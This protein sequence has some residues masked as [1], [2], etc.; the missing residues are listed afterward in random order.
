MKE[1]TKMRNFSLILSAI[2][3]LASAGQT[4]A[5]AAPT[6]FSAGC[7]TA[8]VKD[9]G[10]AAD[11]TTLDT[12]AINKTIEACSASGGGTVYF[13]AGTYLSGSIR[14]KSNIA[15]Y[16]DAGATIL[17]ASNDINAYDQ[18]ED[19]T[20]DMYQDFGHSHWHNSLIWGENL[21]NITIMGPGTINGGGMTRGD[22]VPGG[23]DKTIA[24]KL[25]R[26][27]LIKDIT[28][29]HAGHFAI[30]LTGCDNMVID[31]VKVDTNRDGINLDCCRNVRVSN[32]TINSPFDDAL[33]LKS[34]YALGYKRATEN[35]TITNCMVS[36]YVEGTMLDGTYD[37]TFTRHEGTGGIK[38]GT[39]SN[40]GFKNIV[41]D[42]CVFDNCAGFSLEIVDGGIME[43]INISNITARDITSVPIFIRLGNR[44]R[45]PDNPPVGKIRNINI[46]NVLVTGSYKM[47]GS[48]ITGI[49]GHP[50]ENIRL[51]NIKIIYDGGGTKQDAKIEP[52][53]NEKSYPRSDMFGT[54]PSY[55]FYCRHVKGLEFHNVELGFEEQ[56]LRPALICDDVIDLELDNFKAERAAGGEPSIVLKNVKDIRVH[57]PN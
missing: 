32:C 19:N 44:A 37:N 34:S 16:L 41:I 5:A 57:G 33:C 51:N 49:P 24:L 36:G 26:N 48:S 18:P 46:S 11:G 40:G 13:P 20:F 43:N 56:D 54:L 2:L 29:R 21:E 25:C 45:G 27:I 50:V 14:L 17:G 47:C 30:L 15:L 53:E 7:L 28:I 23:G 38:F 6:V 22:P 9:Y 52:S 1:N 3:V 4:A 39:E 12:A 42:N 10:A 31:S 55:G 35:V 8:N